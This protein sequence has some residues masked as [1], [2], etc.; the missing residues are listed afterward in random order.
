MAAKR[1]SDAVA[2]KI[3]ES[4]AEKKTGIEIAA[5]TGINHNT[6]KPALSWMILNGFIV[7]HRE[8]RGM[9]YTRYSQGHAP[10][11]KGPKGG[12]L[13]KV[14]GPDFGP[15]SEFWPCSRINAQDLKPEP[16]VVR[17]MR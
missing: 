2:M 10:N 8:S 17:E 13:A 9:R 1:P 15:L 11:G 5:Y 12:F 4:C 7:G 3:W 14:D 16:A 6:V